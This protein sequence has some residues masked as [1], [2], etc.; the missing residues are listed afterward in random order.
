M[1]SIKIS[2]PFFLA[3]T[4]VFF[5]IEDTSTKSIFILILFMPIVLAFV[6]KPQI[7]WWGYK[8]NPPLLHSKMRMILERFS[9]YYQKLNADNRTRF[10]QRMSLFMLS[11]SYESKGVEVIPEDLKGLIGATFTKLT[12][13]LEQ[14]LTPKHEVVVLYH[15]KFRTPLIK[16][17]H[18]SE[19]FED[20][21]FGGTIFSLDFIVPG[22]QKPASYNIVLHEFANIVWQQEGWSE[23]DFIAYATPQNLALLAKIRKINLDNIQRTLGKPKLNFFA[24]VVEHF[25]AAPQHFKTL[26]PELYQEV[27]NKLNQDPT[28]ETNPVLSLPLN[29]EKKELSGK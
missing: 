17:P 27:A 3:I 9:T 25:F 2:I 26:L 5:L 8:R 19:V 6:F 7:D 29:K 23:K 21:Q 13:G 16:T 28:N 12:F 10:E 1:L 22:L 4:A 24:V 18:T 15:Q 11:R 14:Y 20:G